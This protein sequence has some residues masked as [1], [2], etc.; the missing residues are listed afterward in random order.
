MLD[1]IIESKVSDLARKF[2][3]LKAFIYPFVI[4]NH[5]AKIKGTYLF[6]LLLVED[7]Q[8]SNSTLF[9]SFFCLGGP[10]HHG[11]CKDCLTWPNC[12]P[13]LTLLTRFGVIKVSLVDNVLDRLD[14]NFLDRF[15]PLFN[16]TFSKDWVDYFNILNS[17]ALR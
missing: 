15:E 4:I 17:L 13:F 1:Q 11:D 5:A 2:K 14:H 10:F 8:T 16:V 12:N 9:H 3:K 7:F 6:V